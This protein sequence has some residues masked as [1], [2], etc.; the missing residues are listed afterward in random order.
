MASRHD[1]CD[2]FFSSQEI[3]KTKKVESPKVFCYLADVGNCASDFFFPPMS[4]SMSLDALGDDILL[5]LLAHSDI[6]TVLSISM[7]SILLKSAA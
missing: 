7:V 4:P 2:L 1:F 6:Y 3:N 5:E